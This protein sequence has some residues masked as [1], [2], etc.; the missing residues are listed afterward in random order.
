MAAEAEQNSADFLAS[1]GNTCGQ[2]FRV[3][4]VIAECYRG[5]IQWASV[6]APQCIA[7][8][9]GSALLAGAESAAV[10]LVTACAAAAVIVMC[11]ED[12]NRRR[13][14]LAHHKSC[15]CQNEQYN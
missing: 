3:C 14:S 9:I 7:S 4:P 6:L 10:R 11:A 1:S 15:D 13:I 5:A 12:I 8:G 2:N